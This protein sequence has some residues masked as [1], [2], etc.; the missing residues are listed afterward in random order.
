M[1]ISQIKRNAKKNLSGKWGL[2]IGLFLIMG[3]LIG[4]TSFIFVGPII[5]A[6]PLML[7]FYI[8]YLKMQR[9]QDVEFEELFS[10]FNNFVTSMVTYLLIFIYTFLW[11][12]LFIIP[13]II[14]AL[15]YS[16]SLF[17][18]ADNPNMKANEAITK[19]KEM[20]NGHKWELFV[21]YLSFIGWMLLTILTFGILVIYVGPYM[22][23]S[24]AAFYEEIKGPSISVEEPNEFE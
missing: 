2:A 7:G 16:M 21:L 18:L 11:S 23:A 5:I 14:K 13:G 19:S 22:Y 3:L 6:G 1:S 20:M 15:S 8:C 10:G 24:L 12:L 4:I 17:I 9:N